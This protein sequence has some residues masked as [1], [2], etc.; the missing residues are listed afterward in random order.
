MNP[1]RPRL[2]WFLWILSW[3]AMLPG[4]LLAQDQERRCDDYANKVILLCGRLPTLSCQGAGGH[5]CYNNV[6]SFSLYRNACLAGRLGNAEYQRDLTTAQALVDQCR[7]G[8]P[9]PPP[10]RPTTPAASRPCPDPLAN[11]YRKLLAEAKVLRGQIEQQ[12]QHPLDLERRAEEPRLVL[13]EALVLIDSAGLAPG[14]VG[15]KEELG[16]AQ[17]RL[18]EPRANLARTSAEVMQGLE[19]Q[20]RIVA[21]QIGLISE[22]A[23]SQGCALPPTPPPEP[24]SVPTVRLL[25][26]TAAVTV[27]TKPASPHGASSAATAIIFVIDTTQEALS[28]T[29]A[30]AIGS[31]QAPQ[32]SGVTVV[33]TGA[34]TEGTRI[35]TPEGTVRSERTLYLVARDPARALTF[36]HVSRGAVTATPLRGAAQRLGAGQ[37]AIVSTMG[38]RLVGATTAAAAGMEVDTDRNGS[39]YANFD[40]PAANPQLC[41]DRCR[42]DANCR[43]WTYVKPGV[44]GPSAR[45]YLKNPAPPTTPNAC[46]IS[47]TIAQTAEAQAGFEVNSNRVGS[48]YA[49]FNLAQAVPDQ[50][51]ARCSADARCA[52]WTYVRPGVQG[53]SARCYLKDPAPPATPNNCCVSGLRMDMDTDRYGSDYA[54]FNLPAANPQLCQQRCE[55]DPNCRAWTY[56]KPG[57]RGPSASCYLKNPAPAPTRNGCCISGAVKRA[58]DAQAFELNTN[59][60]GSDYASFDLAQAVPDQCFERC[61]SDNRCAAWTFV[62]P[63]VQGPNARCYL[64]NPAP[65]PTANSCCVSGA[66]A[67]RTTTTPPPPPPPG[68]GGDHLIT[69]NATQVRPGAPIEIT[70]RRPSTSAYLIRAWIGMAQVGWS[71]ERY[72]SQWK[73]LENQVSGT[74]TLPAPYEPGNYEVRMFPDVGADKVVASAPFTVLASAPSVVLPPVMPPPTTANAS[75]GTVWNETESNQNAVWTRRPGTNTFDASWSNGHVRAVLDMSVQ[76]N[77][78]TVRRTQSTDGY[79]CVYTGTITGNQVSGTF[80]CNRFAGQIPW[81]ATI[82]GE[83]GVTTPPP[84][85]PPPPVVPPPV[86]TPTVLGSPRYLGCFRDPNSP[87]DLDGHL[88]RSAQNTPERCIQTCAAKGFRY[89]GVQYAESCLC[90]H[91]YGRFG[92]A[93]NCNMACTGNPR[94]VCGG[95]NANSVY[96]TGIAPTAPVPGTPTT[97]TPTPPPPPPTPPPQPSGALVLK[98]QATNM[99]P[100]NAQWA[101]TNGR[102]TYTSYSGDYRANGLYSWNPPPPV[103]GPEGFTLTL[104]AQCETGSR[105]GGG[106]S[107]GAGISGNV[108]FLVSATDRRRAPTDAPAQCVGAGQNVRNGVTVHLVPKSTYREGETVALKVSIAWAGGVTYTYIA[109]RQR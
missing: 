48:D 21:N 63:G 6:N 52:A 76:G 13:G 54:N 47:G 82:Q 18:D 64:K 8:I 96:D 37:A 46:C 32:K 98:L 36:V 7:P 50:C 83:V 103:I 101:V 59:R 19:E 104:Q 25:G 72:L 34:S 87:F 88:E 79:D 105:Q 4:P 71:T 67:G 97:R 10:T 17:T 5:P 26:K 91:S 56:V 49:S 12:R 40:L 93:S 39:D 73:Y 106:F 24:R 9:P 30:M 89:A 90:G 60:L 41:Q 74:M 38:V 14:R 2:L 45:C 92:P 109:T 15:T 51:A 62:R 77:Q 75:L 68:G 28:A 99:D 94:Q 69:L 11:T 31:G 107:T 57:Q 35:A 84:P 1:S 95:G 29:D 58:S 78:V 80:G 65:P 43:A 22:R 86:T 27:V 61:R 20:Q 66:I 55:G 81:R 100:S 3:L 33:E 16:K 44:Q 70:F 102:I 108:D 53:P 23:E 85:P 42:G